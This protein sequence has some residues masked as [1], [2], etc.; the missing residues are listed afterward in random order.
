MWW[1][2]SEFDESFIKTCIEESDKWYFLEADVQYS[3][4]LMFIMI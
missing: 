2:Y 4:N 3:K 1:R